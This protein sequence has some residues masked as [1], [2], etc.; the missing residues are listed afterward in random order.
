MLAGRTLVAC[1]ALAWMVVSA[2]VQ[3]APADKQEPPAKQAAIDAFW[4]GDFAALEQQNAQFRKPGSFDAEGVLQLDHFRRGLERVYTSKVVNIESYL[5]EV[6]RLTLE[7]ATQHPQ[8][9]LAHIMHARALV[10]HGWS[11]RG[12]Q[13][14]REVPEEAM[15]DFEKWLLRAVV[16]LK[17]HQDV[18]FKDSYAHLTMLEIGKALGW[19]RKQMLAI[20]QQGLVVNPQDTNLHLEFAAGL[21]PKW[22]GNPR[23]LEDYIKQATI[24]TSSVYGTGMYALLYASAANNQYEHALF[25]DSFADWT[26][27][28]QGYEDLLARYPASTA[29]RNRYAWMA[30]M[31]KDSP[32]LMTLL[33]QIG[34]AIDLDQWGDNP[35]R[36]LE[37]CRRFATQL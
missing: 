11:Y 24:Q 36:S 29:K 23:S 8:S 22:G 20:A 30:C 4:H 26:K 35:E 13:Y 25:T 32:V 21:L 17:D 12:G 14:A 7:W 28:K 5:S 34:T 33:G 16:Y 1:A 10:K 18:A 19:D 6:D 31:A 15:A 9:P 2:T 27:I 3:A 37:M